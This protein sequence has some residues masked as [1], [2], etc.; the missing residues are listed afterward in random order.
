M[1]LKAS[2]MALIN[3]EEIAFIIVGIMPDLYY[4]IQFLILL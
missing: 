1:W 4:V 3:D 2:N